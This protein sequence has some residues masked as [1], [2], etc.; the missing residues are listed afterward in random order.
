MGWWWCWRV[1]VKSRGKGAKVTDLMLKNKPFYCCS[2]QRTRRLFPLVQ[3]QMFSFC[4]LNKPLL[5]NIDWM[6]VT[7]I[8]GIVW[9][10]WIKLRSPCQFINISARQTDEL[11]FLPSNEDVVISV[12]SFCA[13]FK[14]LKPCL[15]YQSFLGQRP[16]KKTW[17]KFSWTS[18]TVYTIKVIWGTFTRNHGK[19]IKIWT[20][21]I[22]LQFYFHKCNILCIAI[23]RHHLRKVVRK[24]KWKTFVDILL[25]LDQYFVPKAYVYHI[26]PFILLLTLKIEKI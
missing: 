2:Q 20:F 6:S 10:C 23:L 8:C 15:H 11:N 3:V 24:Y 12:F 14:R 9:V 19:C 21:H 26:S 13:E 22:K 18:S 17:S 4:T 1:F 5:V 16:S 7:A 25:Y